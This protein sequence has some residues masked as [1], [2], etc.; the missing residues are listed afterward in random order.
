MR[1][2]EAW[3]YD[4]AIRQIREMKQNLEEINQR[5]KEATAERDILLAQFR[6]AETIL[7]NEFYKE[8]EMNR[9]NIEFLIKSY[10]YLLRDSGIRALVD[11]L[12]QPSAR[13]AFRLSTPIDLRVPFG[14]KQR[15]YFSKGVEIL[16]GGKAAF[17]FQK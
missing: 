16:L 11:A 4:D 2:A 9:A 1:D 17:S 14:K 5:I 3:I 8:T 15:V 12:N 10:G 7:K 13:A 6:R